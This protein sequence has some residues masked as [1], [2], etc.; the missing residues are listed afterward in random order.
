MTPESLNQHLSDVSLHLSDV[1]LHLSDVSLHLS[2][3][4]LDDIL[5]GDTTPAAQAHLAACETC[6]ARLAPFEATLTHFN[7]ATIAWAEAKSNTISR[8]LSTVQPAPRLAP[9]I[10]WSA[11]VA[12][13][14]TVG[15]A[16]T[17]A[18]HPR[19]AGLDAQNK[20]TPALVNAAAKTDPAHEQ[21]QEIADDNAMLLAIDAAVNRP[22]PSPIEVYHPTAKKVRVD[23]HNAPQV[24]Y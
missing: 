24:I 12:V 7:Q 2:D 23:R 10:A 14:V 18:I 15:L 3:D 9:T 4:A 17:S 6:R 20:S 16:I 1:S 22:E 21:T 11:A 8:D 19:G 13:L 5:I